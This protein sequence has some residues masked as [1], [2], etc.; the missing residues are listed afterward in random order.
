MITTK[1][2]LHVL[3]VGIGV[4]L[5]SGCS[6][7]PAGGNGHSGTGLEAPESK[8]NAGNPE[9]EKVTPAVS[10][11][12]AFGNL[13]PRYP[14]MALLLGQQGTTKL[15]ILVTPEDTARQ[16]DVIQSSGSALLDDEA[17]ATVKGWRFKPATLDDTPIAGW[18]IQTISFMLPSGMAGK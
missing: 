1:I 12:E 11:M 3:M 5:L 2:K 4:A 10:S 17:V 15:K 6:H 13:P 9:H 14:Q 16:V 7:Q 18:A 8:V